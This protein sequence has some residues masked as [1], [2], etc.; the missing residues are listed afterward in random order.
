MTKIKPEY[1]AGGVTDNI[2]LPTETG[3]KIKAHAMQASCLRFSSSGEHIATGGGDSLVKIWN[4]KLGNEMQVLRGLQKPV[5][6]LAMSLDGEFLL[7]SSLE[8]K[9]LLWKLKTMRTIFA[10]TGHNDVINACK[11]SFTKRQ[12][13]TGSMDRTIRYWDIDRGVQTDTSIC[14][15]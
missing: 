11:F 10:F 6:D 2:D 14:T 15:S 12:A 7:A 4:S 9:A 13:I 5:T 1:I 3:I 8:N